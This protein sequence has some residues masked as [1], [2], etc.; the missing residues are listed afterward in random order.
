MNGTLKANR[1]FAAL[2][3]VIAWLSVGLRV[4]I[5]VSA[6]TAEGRS[7]LDGF[8]TVFSYFTIQTNFI[9]ALVATACALRDERVSYL[10]RPQTL[11][12]VTVYIVIVGIIYAVLLAGLRQLTGLAV[13]VDIGL[14]RVVPVLFVLYWLAFVPKGRLAWRDALGWLIFP[15]LYVIYSLIYGALTDRYLY[16][17][18]NVSVLG[19]PRA[20]GNAGVIVLAFYLLGL[21]LIALDRL[22]ARV[23]PAAGTG[24]PPRSAP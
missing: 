24:K 16:P 13:F 19:Y 22:L 15:A 18:S 4:W 1:L 5:V 7:V 10:T 9:L 23:R 14:H 2:I 11:A 3:A 6:V 21:A 8:I 12:A 20:L 17:F